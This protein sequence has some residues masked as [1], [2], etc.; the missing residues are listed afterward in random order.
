M[1]YLLSLLLVSVLAGCTSMELAQWTSAMDQAAGGGSCAYADT[2]GDE[3]SRMDITYKSGGYAGTIVVQGDLI[4][5]SLF[6][7]V[8]SSV[9]QD[10]SCQITVSG[11]STTMLVPANGYIN[12]YEMGKLYSSS[13]DTTVECRSAS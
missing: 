3:L 13:I 5:D 1:R 2:Y 4:C 10:M 8:M 9:P 11:L 12:D 6:L 7:D